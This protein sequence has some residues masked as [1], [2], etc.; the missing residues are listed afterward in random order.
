MALY[1]MP[2]GFKIFAIINLHQRNET[3]TRFT[4]SYNFKLYLARFHGF[5]ILPIASLGLIKF[6]IKGLAIRVW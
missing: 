1:N 4:H 6:N 3:F 2:N 5:N